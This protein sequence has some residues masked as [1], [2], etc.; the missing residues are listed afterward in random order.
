MSSFLI[1]FFFCGGESSLSSIEN[2]DLFY[3]S[4]LVLGAALLFFFIAVIRWF[5]W[6]ILQSGWLVVWSMYCM[7]DFSANIFIIGPMHHACY[8]GQ[9]FWPD[10]KILLLDDYINMSCLY[11][12]KKLKP[13]RSCLM[14]FFFFFFPHNKKFTALPSNVLWGWLDSCVSVSC[15][16][17]DYTSIRAGIRGAVWCNWLF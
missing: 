13:G 16:Q 5:I 17:G 1:F 9:L 10:S 4:I 14:D 8:W 15:I 6:I 11:I 3:L 12:L 2:W 7:T